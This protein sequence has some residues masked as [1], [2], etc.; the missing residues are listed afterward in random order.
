MVCQP[1]CNK[2]EEGDRIMFEEL[3]APRPI[4]SIRYTKKQK[5][6]FRQY[7]K[8]KLSSKYKIESDKPLKKNYNIII[9]DIDT[10]DVIMTAHYDTPK[11]IST[12]INHEWHSKK[13]YQRKTN[14]KCAITSLVLVL[15]LMVLVLRLNA[16]TFI[17]IALIVLLLLSFWYI[18]FSIKPT[19]PNN[20]NDNTS[21]V[22]TVLKTAYELN[23][24][25]RDKVAFVLFDNE[26]NYCKG[27]SSLS[28]LKKLDF[29][30]KLIINFDCVGVGNTFM[31]FTKKVAEEYCNQLKAAYVTAYDKEVIFDSKLV[32]NS[33]HKKFPNG[34]GVMAL[35]L[36]ED[37]DLFVKKMHSVYDTHLDLSNI[38][39][40]VKSNLSFFSSI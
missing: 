6:A 14:H 17:Q 37:G 10:A 25:N 2:S 7:V 5:Q 24:E 20:M 31:F 27:S 23:V 36:S 40:L 29:N 8:D 32:S 21:G 12:F 22:L 33:D 11:T 3:V 26:E 38:S 15:F 13:N 34:V 4:H 28:K 39:F 16:S 1:G 19:N 30:N 35:I 18:V 9:G